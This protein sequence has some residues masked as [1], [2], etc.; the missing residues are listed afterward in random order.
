MFSYF[1]VGIQDAN[2][3]VEFYSDNNLSEFLQTKTRRQG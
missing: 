2:I 3:K 1:N